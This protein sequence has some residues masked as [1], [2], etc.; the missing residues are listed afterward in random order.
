VIGEKKRKFGAELSAFDKQP[1]Q[2]F[3]VSRLVARVDENGCCHLLLHLG[4]R[5]LDDDLREANI[6]TSQSRTLAATCGI[7]RRQGAGFRRSR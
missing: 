7:K 3:L 5:A 2:L 6:K 4:E 1:P